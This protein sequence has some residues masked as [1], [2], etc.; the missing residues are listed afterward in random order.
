M[1]LKRNEFADNIVREQDESQAL[2]CQNPP[3]TSE[4]EQIEVRLVTWRNNHSIASQRA[5]I[6]LGAGLGVGIAGIL[7][8][9]LLLREAG[10]RTRQ[11]KSGRVATWTLT[12]SSGGLVVS[13]SF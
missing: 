1:L 5:G 13:G 11:W 8:G 7:T 4:C 12:P 9:A 2:G 3:T 10:I 6:W